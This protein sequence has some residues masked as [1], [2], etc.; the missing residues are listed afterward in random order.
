VVRAGHTEV[1]TDTV[2]A[3]LGRPPISFA[4]FVKEHRAAW[5]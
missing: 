4:R 2:Q 5:A 3:V 1:K